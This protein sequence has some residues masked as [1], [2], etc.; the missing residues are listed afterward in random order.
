M[1]AAQTPKT[2]A[3]AAEPRSFEGRL[4]IEASTSRTIRLEGREYL[5]FGGCGYLALA[6]DPRVIAKAREAAAR[7]G[8]SAG[9]ARETT[10]NVREHDE[11][12]QRIAQALGMEAALLLPEGALANLAVGEAFAGAWE[13]AWL[14]DEA[15]VS[16]RRG[17]ELCQPHGARIERIS[18]D[19]QD[20]SS[21]REAFAAV[22]GARAIWSDSVF[23]SDGRLAPLA[24]WSKLL[25]READA[26]VVDDCHGFGVLGAR[27]RG[28]LEHAGLAGER[29]VIVGTLSKALGTY[30]GFVAASRARVERIRRRS[31]LYL[32][33]TPLSPALAAAAL[34]A[35]EIHVGEPAR[36]REY[37]E[38]LRRFRAGLRARGFSLPELEFPVFALRLGDEATTR[39]LHQRGLARGV[40]LPFVD[41]P[42]QSGKLLRIVWNAAHTESDLERLLD[43]LAPD[44][45]PAQQR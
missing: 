40:F 42:G 23:P 31:G 26:L 36:H 27:G 9:A 16:V 11:L 44:G 17:V 7:H 41:Y 37:L 32:G 20:A 28:A 5:F 34:A 30:G 10:G 2:S 19:A 1:S 8:I 45:V 25:D 3:S 14:P 18:I 13:S 15:H 43:V 12:E 4:P 24:A 29:A 38:S 35:L 33:T 39:A 6:H 21:Q 22:R